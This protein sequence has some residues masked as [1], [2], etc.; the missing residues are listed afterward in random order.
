MKITLI[1]FTVLLLILL[2]FAPVL[3]PTTCL[4]LI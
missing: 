1:S 2:S 4:G 3:M